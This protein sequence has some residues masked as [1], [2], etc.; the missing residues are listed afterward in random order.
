[1]K[2]FVIELLTVVAA[3]ALM[4][5]N[6]LVALASNCSDHAESE[7]EPKLQQLVSKAYVWGWPL[8]YLSNLQKSVRLISRPGVSGGSPIAPI[9]RLSML[10]APVTE[11]FTSVPCPN[12]DVIYGFAILDLAKQPVILQIP[13]IDHRLWVIQVGDHRT[14]SFGQLGSMYKTKPGFYA[15]VGPQWQGELPEAVTEV[16]QSSTNLAY[17][18]PRFVTAGE[19]K[20]GHDLQT[21]QQAITRLSVYPL[22]QFNGKWKVQDWSKQTWFPA[23]GQ[24]TR[25]SCKF[26]NPVK[27]FDDLANVMEVVPPLPGEESL[28]QQIRELLDQQKIDPQL[29]KLLSEYAEQLEQERIAPLFDFH[30]VGKQVG[31]NW[32][33]VDNGASFG[34][35]YETRTAVAKSNIFVARANEAKYFHV[36]LDRD[37]QLFQGDRDY[38][39]RIPFDQLPPNAGYW[40]LTIYDENHRLS[41]NETRSIAGTPSK[42]KTS[43]DGSI[44]IHIS[45]EEPR[46]SN[47]NWLPTPNGKFSLYLRVYVPGESVVAGAWKPPV[48]NRIDHQPLVLISA[49]EPSS[50][51]D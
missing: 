17:I 41:S 8:V 23:I 49:T 45:H 46:H 33:T 12:P 31:N 4:L 3:V 37:G 22:N 47:V 21:L 26:V 34:T 35:D 51:F 19:A 11:Q 48:V 38:Q 40:S 6:N 15:I 25:E 20:D 24:S 10:T 5:S 16:L 28:Y 1:M 50:A 27:F 2:R 39:I 36:E 18:I 44:V 43:A 13:E 7:L 29:S 32:T 14:D 42:L 9:N 30:R